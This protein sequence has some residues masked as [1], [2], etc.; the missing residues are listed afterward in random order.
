LRPPQ[1]NGHAGNGK[2]PAKT[3]VTARGVVRKDAREDARSPRND[4][5]PALAAGAKA[6]NS[7]RYGFTVPSKRGTKKRG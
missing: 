7:K 2:S 6:G 5:K 1:R 3:G 4:R